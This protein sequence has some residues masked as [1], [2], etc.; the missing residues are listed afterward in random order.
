MPRKLKARQR[1]GLSV[2][3]R[4]ALLTPIQAEITLLS[5]TAEGGEEPLESQ[6]R[7]LKGYRRPSDDI[8]FR[9]LTSEHPRHFKD[10][11]PKDL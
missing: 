2:Q 6:E 9:S 10:Y 11:P 3:R 8:L 4:N 7:R 5:A 1:V